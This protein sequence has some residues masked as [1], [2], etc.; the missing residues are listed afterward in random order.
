M[1]YGRFVNLYNLIPAVNS[2]NEPKTPLQMGLE[3]AEDEIKAHKEAERAKKRDAA[4]Q[5]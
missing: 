5:I 3:Q 1:S 4:W 2:Q